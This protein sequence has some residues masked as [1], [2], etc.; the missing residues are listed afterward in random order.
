MFSVDLGL[1]R[2]VDRVEEL[3]RDSKVFRSSLLPRSPEIYSNPKGNLIVAPASL[4]S[5]LEG[6]PGEREFRRLSDYPAVSV[7]V[8]CQKI[9]EISRGDLHEVHCTVI[10]FEEDK[11]A[12]V[13]DADT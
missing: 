5:V 8:S 4:Q 11:V 9:K 12:I 13:T 10:I 1:M 2:E 3:E 7:S 6:T